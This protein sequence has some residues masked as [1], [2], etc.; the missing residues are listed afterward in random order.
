MN[1]NNFKK[2]L[3]LMIL[4]FAYKL[5]DFQLE[6]AIV[7]SSEPRSGSTWLAEILHFKIK[8]SV[9]NW[10]PLHLSEGVVP[11]SL[12]YGWQPFIPGNSIN[13]DYSL[14]LEKV[15]RGKLA[16]D[17]TL[18]LTGVREVIAAKYVITKLVRANLLLP[19][20]IKNFPEVK[21]IFLLRHPVPTCI[22]QLKNFQKIKEEE[23]WQK[24]IKPVY[25][26]SE[27][28]NNDL[29]KGHLKYIDS[30]NSYIEK[31]ISIWCV[32]NKH[33]LQQLDDNEAIRVYYE[34]LI[35]NPEKETLKIINALGK[36]G[37]FLNN[38]KFNFSKP[39]SSDFSTSFKR[40]PKLQL[41]KEF[42]TWDQD[43]WLKIQNIL[44]YFNIKSYEASNPYPI[45]K[46]FR[47]F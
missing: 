18:I 47:Q 24:A 34:E 25:G 43:K 36:N 6:N 38:E 4:K 45:T 39:S 44:D 15:F 27:I 21:P 9:I 5:K 7:I 28:M 42:N 12:N 10:E 8:N 13:K 46:N 35:I 19:F 26:Y 17:Y 16:T 11:K 22:S 30:L 23:L 41:E 37:I 3:R 20:I 40:N 29:L 32:F 14:F 2:R 33:N 1:Q 31:K